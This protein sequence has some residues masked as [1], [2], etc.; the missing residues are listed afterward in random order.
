MTSEFVPIKPTI[1]DSSMLPSSNIDIDIESQ[2][3]L[4]DSNKGG[5]DKDS[6]GLQSS[7]FKKVAIIG[8]IIVII[9]LL[10]IALYYTY[11]Y[12]KSKYDDDDDDDDDDRGYYRKKRHRRPD[13]GSSQGPSQGPSQG[14]ELRPSRKIKND[15][16]LKQFIT[17]KA[18]RKTPIHESNSNKSLIMSKGNLTERKSDDL[19]HNLENKK[20][21]SIPEEQ[22]HKL[23][24]IDTL[25]V[26]ISK[27][28]LVEEL[29]KEMKEDSL[30]DSF[31][32]NESLDPEPLEP[33]S[34]EP[35]SKNGCEHLIEQGD[36]KGDRCG[37][38]AKYING[39]RC[40][41]HRKK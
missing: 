12:F 26:S 28:Q 40:Y 37:R 7:T 21:E 14:L 22:T 38:V 9:I 23:N 34:L 10:I 5:K 6:G 1:T 30:F 39:T 17:D 11:D 31:E 15:E 16:Y 32:L 36:K 2:T 19:I 27:E 29:N 41:H 35:T 25:S 13:K 33:E 24:E 8:L 4:D 20:L 18:V 3:P